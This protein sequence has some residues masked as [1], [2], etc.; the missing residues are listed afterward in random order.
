MQSARAKGRVAIMA[1]L[2]IDG[3]DLEGTGSPSWS[4][5]GLKKVIPAAAVI[6]AQV[7]LPASLSLNELDK[8]NAHVAASAHRQL[9]LAVRRRPYPA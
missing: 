5:G 4:S 1:K 9:R 2:T 7:R 3:L 6:S 8:S